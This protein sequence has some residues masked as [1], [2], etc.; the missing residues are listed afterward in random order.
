LRL[1][2]NQTNR[3]NNVQAIFLDTERQQNYASF[4][5]QGV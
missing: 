3:N 5:I 1:C 2:V 4:V